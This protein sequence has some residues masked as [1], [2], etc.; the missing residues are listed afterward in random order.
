[1]EEHEDYPYSKLNYREAV[2]SLQYLSSKTR[3]DLSFA[4]NYE[5]RS[6]DN[7]KKQDFINVKRNLR[8]LKGTPSK[9]IKY[10]KSQRKDLELIAYC[11]AD[12]AGDK[13]SREKD[14]TKEIRRKSTSG[15]VILMSGGPIS[16]SPRRQKV[17]AQSTMEAELIAANEC[18][19]EL[20]HLTE[21]LNKEMTGKEVNSKIYI[22][23]QSTIKLIKAGRLK[24]SRHIEVKYFFNKD[25]Y[26]KG[27]FKMEY[28][29]SEENHSDI[30]TKPLTAVIPFSRITEQ[31]II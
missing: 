19:K 10:Y 9:G 28:V 29:P 3:P 17:V 30:F 13:D 23:N 11:D 1:M 15:F 25:E 7:P 24:T 22:D 31:L 14:Q 18:A 8:Y 6:L 2:G 27:L 26:Q 4:V 20:K 16:W 12:Y 5:S 21:L